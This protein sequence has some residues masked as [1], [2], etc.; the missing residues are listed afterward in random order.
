M[1][2]KVIESFEVKETLGHVVQVPG[3]EN[4]DAHS[5]DNRT[6]R[7]ESAPASPWVSL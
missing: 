7:S 4:R 3:S 1:F 2:L 5:R 6:G